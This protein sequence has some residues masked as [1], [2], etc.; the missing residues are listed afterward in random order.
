MRHAHALHTLCRFWHLI[1]STPATPEAFWRAVTLSKDRR[2][3]YVFVTD[4]V[5]P[6]PW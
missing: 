3:G 6:N 5:M 4:D 1:H 2:A